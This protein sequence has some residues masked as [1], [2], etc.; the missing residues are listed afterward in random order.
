[1]RLDYDELFAA[2][3]YQGHFLAIQDATTRDEH[4]MLV[5]LP[6]H[7]TKTVYR[8]IGDTVAWICVCT[9]LMVIGFAL[10]AG[11]SDPHPPCA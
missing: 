1:V 7:R 6:L 9:V 3:D 5:D 8:Q 10:L 11:R 4:M 2:F